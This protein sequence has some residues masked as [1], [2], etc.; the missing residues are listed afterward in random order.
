MI[1]RKLNL[2]K[3]ILLETH[4]WEFNQHLG[5]S[6][7]FA[8][9]QYGPVLTDDLGTGSELHVIDPWTNVLINLHHFWFLPSSMMSSFR[10]SVLSSIHFSPLNTSVVSLLN[11]S[12]WMSV[13][14]LYLYNIMYLWEE[15]LELFYYWKLYN[16]TCVTWRVWL[17][18]WWE[19]EVLACQASIITAVMPN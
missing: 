9:L 3:W 7:V 13:F 12:S 17:I 2:N 6:F 18:L 1:G 10:K 4:L 8:G 14:L 11:R 5:V 19:V 16:D 15:W